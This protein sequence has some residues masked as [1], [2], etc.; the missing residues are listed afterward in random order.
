MPSSSV[1][2]SANTATIRSCH[3]ELFE[4][5][6][7]LSKQSNQSNPL[8]A[9]MTKNSPCQKSSSGLTTLMKVLTYL[10]D[11]SRATPKAQ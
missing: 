6:L 7:R 8:L 4:N 9:I 5:A 2:C 3:A 11:G 1:G 10:V